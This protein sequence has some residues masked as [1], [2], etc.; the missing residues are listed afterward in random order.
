MDQTNPVDA[1]YDKTMDR[2]LNSAWNHEGWQVLV[3]KL[4]PTSWDLLYEKY[5]SKVDLVDLHHVFFRNTK[6]S[7]TSWL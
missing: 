6:S 7:Y 3:N 1:K 4:R 2:V 5:V